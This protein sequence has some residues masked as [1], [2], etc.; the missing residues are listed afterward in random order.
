MEKRKGSHI[1]VKVEVDSEN[2]NVNENAVESTGQSSFDLATNKPDVNYVILF[3]FICYRII[4]ILSYKIQYIYI[5]F[6]I[7]K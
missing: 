1:D 5:T 7:K 2:E 3:I 6:Y 4:Y